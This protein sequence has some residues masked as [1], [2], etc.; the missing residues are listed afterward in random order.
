MSGA[1]AASHIGAYATA[2]HR[3]VWSLDCYPGYGVAVV[4]ENKKPPAQSPSAPKFVGRARTMDSAEH[5]FAAFPVLVAIANLTGKVGVVFIKRLVLSGKIK[6][7]TRNAAIIG[8]VI[9]IVIVLVIACVIW[10]AL[11]K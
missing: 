5:L 3:I 6:E 2:A 4:T 11:L 10:L 1:F 7:A 8:S 9:V